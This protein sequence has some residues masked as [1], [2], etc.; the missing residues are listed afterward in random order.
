[1][2]NRGL[3]TTPECPVFLYKCLR[4]VCIILLALENAYVEN[5]F[6]TLIWEVVYL[7]RKIFLILFSLYDFVIFSFFYFKSL[8]SLTKTGIWLPSC[9]LTG[10]IKIKIYNSLKKSLINFIWH[11]GHIGHFGAFFFETIFWYKMHAL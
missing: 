3:P 2:L 6:P 10:K 1:M 7:H 8:H 4:N 5:S 11:P 9:W